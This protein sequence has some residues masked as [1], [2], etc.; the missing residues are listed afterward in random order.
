MAEPKAKPRTENYYVYEF[1][2]L[3]SDHPD[4]IQNDCEK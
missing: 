4:R 2:P 1:V 3:K